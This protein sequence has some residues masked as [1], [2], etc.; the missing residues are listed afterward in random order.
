MHMHMQVN[1]DIFIYMNWHLKF[2]LELGCE[3]G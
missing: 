1:I 2:T 3:M